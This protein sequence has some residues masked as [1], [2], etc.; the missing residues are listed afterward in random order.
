MGL[1]RAG[2]RTVS[3]SEI[4]PYASAVLAQRWPGVP[5]LGDILDLSRDRPGSGLGSD[6]SRP[7]SGDLRD[8]RLGDD[9][10]RSPHRDWQDATLWTTEGGDAAWKSAVLW[11]GGFP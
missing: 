5:N 11:T 3:F 2:W 8:G 6:A 1:E 7:I 4:D 9:G 10:S